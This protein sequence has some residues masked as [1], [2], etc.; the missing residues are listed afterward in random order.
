MGHTEREIERI[1]VPVLIVGA[2]AAGLRV[3]IE[4]AGH[5]ACLV[6]G[7]RKHGDAHTVWAAGGVNA[8]LGNLDPEDRWE[9][10]AADTLREGHFL[11]DPQAVERLASEAPE[12][13][14]ELQAW[15]CPFDKTD[16]GKLNQRY[17]GVQSYR[18]TC[19]AGDKTGG[20]ILQTLVAKAR[21]LGV[22]YRQ[23]LYVTRLLKRDGRVVGAAGFDLGDHHPVVIAA[24]A[25][26]VA[27]GGFTSLYRCSWKPPRSVRCRPT[28]SGP[29][30][31]STTSPIITSSEA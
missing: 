13:V 6:V 19:F 5:S 18:R 26:V 27:A 7:K 20:A 14:L 23:D 9:I 16:E 29:S 3:A 10:H 1:E 4:L 24:R 25:V 15:G 28:S 30:R 21:A 11:C 8:A 2:G 22:P 17:F 12:R 31:K